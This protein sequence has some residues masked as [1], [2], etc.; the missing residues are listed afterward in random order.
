MTDDSWLM[1]DED[2]WLMRARPSRSQ[3]GECGGTAVCHRPE[4]VVV[5]RASPHGRGEVRAAPLGL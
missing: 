5:V 4:V 3:G 2:R 1:T